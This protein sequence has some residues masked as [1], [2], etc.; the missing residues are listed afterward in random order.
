M[1]IA[2]ITPASV[3]H[4]IGAGKNTRALLGEH[5]E[6]LPTSRFLEAA[7]ADLK[8]GDVPQVIEHDNGVLHINDLIEQIPH[9]PEEHR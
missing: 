8:S 7:I 2:Q 5:F 1:S 4:A 3:L 9:D 6:V